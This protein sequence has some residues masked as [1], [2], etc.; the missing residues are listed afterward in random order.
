[1]MLRTG[2][3]QGFALIE[4]MFAVVVL[5]FGL[6]LVLRSF[7]TTLEGIKRIEFVKL[8][9]HLLEE[10]MEEIKEK[11]KEEEGIVNGNAFGE[12]EDYKDYNWNLNVNPSDVDEVLNEVKLEISWTEGKNQR[13]IFATTY[14]ANK[15]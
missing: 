3:K 12:F 14:L 4:I 8:A 10:K 1:M 5:S 9:S 2:S 15:D 6:V 7:A 13:S 11:A